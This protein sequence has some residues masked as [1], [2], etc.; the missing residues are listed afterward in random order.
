MIRINC[1][2]CEKPFEIEDDA[3][4]QKAACPYCG[5]INRVPAATAPAAIPIGA[6]V[7]ASSMPATA[8]AA[9]PPPAPAK[10]A[11]SSPVNEAEQTV[12]V[13]RQAMF[14]AHPFWYLLMVAMFFGGIVVAIFSM[15]NQPFAN[16]PWLKWAGVAMVA[17]AF[18]WW[19]G[20]WAAPH[21]W[22]KLTITTKRVIRQEGLLGRSSNDVRHRDIRDILVKQTFFQRLLNVGYLGIDSAGQ[23]GQLEDVPGQPE[24]RSPIEIEM[25]NVPKPNRVKELI[26]KYRI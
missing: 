24:R 11:A 19:F 22:V 7:A 21:R 12:A 18:L 10:P 1:D 16:Q 9:V 5:D 14:R 3:A 4:G 23:S 13:V 17:L 2:N 15:P 25:E 26:N 6:P 8:T 20:W